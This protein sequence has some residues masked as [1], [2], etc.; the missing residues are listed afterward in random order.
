ML[1]CDCFVANCN[2]YYKVVPNSVQDQRENKSPP[3][4]K[5][6]M[7][8]SVNVSELAEAENSIIFLKFPF[9]CRFRYIQVL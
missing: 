9:G 6:G 2:D 1:K 7:L 8:G 5:Q 4:Q 3:N